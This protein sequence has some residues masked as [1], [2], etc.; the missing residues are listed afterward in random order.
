[1]IGQE[2]FK[3]VQYADDLTLFVPNIE[4]AKR[5]LQPL[6]GFTIC[7]GLKVILKL[8]Q[9]GSVHVDK[10][11]RQLGLKW[12]KSVKALGIVFTYNETDQLQN[13]F[14]DKSKDIRTQ[15]RLWN[16]RGLSLFGKV[17]VIKSLLLPK[18]LYV[19]SVLTTPEEFKKT[20]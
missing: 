18:M 9:C 5:I 12:S 8:R 15:I 13:K 10:I 16:C 19:F 20:I 3:L 14:Y 7:S 1:M 4:C 17:T 2:E 11:Q 6:D